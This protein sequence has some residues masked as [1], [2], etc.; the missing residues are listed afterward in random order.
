[1]RLRT[2][3]GAGKEIPCRRARIHPSSGNRDNSP[4]ATGNNAAA[5]RVSMHWRTPR[6]RRGC[7]GSICAPK[8][9]AAHK[10]ALCGRERRQRHLPATAHSRRMCGRSI[11]PV[12]KVGRVPRV[13]AGQANQPRVRGA[14]RGAAHGAAAPSSFA[15][16]KFAAPRPR[17]VHASRHQESAAPAAPL[18]AEKCNNKPGRA[19]RPPA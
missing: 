7:I 4:V 17:H 9:Q 2:R 1:M 11:I 19:C 6:R 10:G 18:S 5:A 15:I 12:G 8:T 3:L 16:K 13:I 14:V